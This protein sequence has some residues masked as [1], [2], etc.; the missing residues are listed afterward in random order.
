MTAFLDDLAASKLAERVVVLCFSE[1]GRTV[2]ENGSTGTDHGTAGPVFL[3][4][5]GVKGGLVGSTPSL[6][7][8]DPKHGDLKVGLDFRAL[9]R[10]G[11][12]N[13]LR[14]I[15]KGQDHPGKRN[16]V[17]CL[18][19]KK[20]ES[21][22]KRPRGWL[23]CRSKTS[24]PLFPCTE[25]LLVTERFQEPTVRRRGNEPRRWSATWV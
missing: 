19:P 1:F 22:A 8:L 13:F 24:R 4:G 21:T 23:H 15:K 10:R 12:E 3:A 14:S 18:I 2:K 11:R 7:D 25:L 5:P 6:M 16:Q 9:P 17:P 20:S